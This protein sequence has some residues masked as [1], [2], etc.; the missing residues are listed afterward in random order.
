MVNAAPPLL[1][2]RPLQLLAAGRDVVMLKLKLAVSTPPPIGTFPAGHVARRDDLNARKSRRARR[3]GWACG[4]GRTGGSGG[5][6]GARGERSG[7]E[8]GRKE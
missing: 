4:T 2:A 6:D 7:L 8:V 3:A 5:T 1:Y